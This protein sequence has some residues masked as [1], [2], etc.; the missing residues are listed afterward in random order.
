M[1]EN[2]NQ[3]VEDE[4]TELE[5]KD[6]NN[7]EPIVEIKNE[8]DKKDETEKGHAEEI[9]TDSIKTLAEEKICFKSGL[10]KVIVH[11]A[12]DLVN[13]D[14]GR[15]DPY[16]KIKYKDQEFKSKTIIN[17]LEPLW[18]FNAD[19]KLSDKEGDIQIDVLDEDFGK[20]SF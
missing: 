5:A 16:L 9:K 12:S 18:D 3:S 14:I 11:G 2:T 19:I 7:K 10:L 4:G 15:S 20:D 6:V 8:S 17:S 13:K 1:I